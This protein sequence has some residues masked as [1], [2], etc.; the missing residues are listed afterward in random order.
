MQLELTR[1]ATRQANSKSSHSDSVGCRLVATVHVSRSML[2]LSVVWTRRPPSMVRR[3]S[4]GN[5]GAG[6]S[7]IRRFFFSVSFANFSNVIHKWSLNIK[8]FSPYNHLDT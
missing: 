6:A 2:T 3:S 7:M 4:K 8:N 1:A 5:P